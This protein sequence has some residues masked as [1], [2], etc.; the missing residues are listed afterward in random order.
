MVKTY[1]KGCR[2]ENRARTMLEK[3]GYYVI[4]SAGS[5]G[6]IDLVAVSWR[7][8]KLIQVKSRGISKAEVDAI[9]DLRVPQNV[10]KEIWLWDV[11]TW[12]FQIQVV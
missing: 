9:M 8:I 7:G 2:L 6:V 5:K 4:R 10:H 12:S 3:Q 1:A 11:N